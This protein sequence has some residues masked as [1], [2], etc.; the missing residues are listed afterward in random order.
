MSS[1]PDMPPP[2]ATVPVTTQLAGLVQK[3]EQLATGLGK[4]QQGL[5]DKLD[6]IAQKLSSGTLGAQTLQKLGLDAN[7][8]PAD[9]TLDAAINALVSSGAAETKAALAPTPKFSKPV[10]QLPVPP[11]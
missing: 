4:D 8:A 5:A 11:P 9:T 6:A 2:D 10:L 3:V 7:S 1:V